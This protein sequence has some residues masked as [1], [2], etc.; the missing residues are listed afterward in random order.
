MILLEITI[1]YLN[2]ICVRQQ[3]LHLFDER[4]LLF[5]VKRRQMDGELRLYFL[6]RVLFL[7][8]IR[9]IKIVYL[10]SN[11]KDSTHGRLNSIFHHL[12]FTLVKRDKSC[13]VLKTILHKTRLVQHTERCRRCCDNYRRLR[14]ERSESSDRHNRCIR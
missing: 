4:Y 9:K 10:N 12:S 13:L 14:W 5:L 1:G 3:A 11:L 8:L 2:K 6:L 7:L